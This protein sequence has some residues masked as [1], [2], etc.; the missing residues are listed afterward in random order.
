MHVWGIRNAAAPSTRGCEGPR[1]WVFSGPFHECCQVFS[2]SPED[3]PVEVCRKFKYCLFA[4]QR[5]QDLKLNPYLLFDYFS[6][7]NK[8]LAL[9]NPY[10]TCSKNAKENRNELG[11]VPSARQREY[12]RSL[13]DAEMLSVTDL[14]NFFHEGWRGALQG[15]YTNTSEN[16]MIIFA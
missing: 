14:G 15:R 4:V 10:Q 6:S 13:S 7:T 2:G 5:I 3:I 9:W 11:W 1:W 12:L 16:N 8:K